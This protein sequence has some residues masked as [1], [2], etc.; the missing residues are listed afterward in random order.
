MD[1]RVGR[2]ASARAR[3]GAGGGRLAPA[4][5][6]MSSRV[7]RLD[8]RIGQLD[9]GAGRLAPNR[10]LLD[11]RVGRLGS[12]VGRFNARVGQLDPRSRRLAPRSSLHTNRSEPSDSRISSARIG[13]NRPLAGSGK[14]QSEAGQ[15]LQTGRS[16]RTGADHPPRSVAGASPGPTVR[17]ELAEGARPE[18]TVRSGLVTAQEPGR[19]DGN[20]AHG[21]RTG[22]IYPH[23]G[24]IRTYSKLPEMFVWPGRDRPGP[25]TSQRMK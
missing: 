12:R 21:S 18:R 5:T 2:L 19:D 17:S 22:S 14:A 1:P 6:L 20:E 23:A 3:L 16:R 25:A 24:S 9:P 10:T 7:G 15:A 11:S 8:S 4:C 13:V